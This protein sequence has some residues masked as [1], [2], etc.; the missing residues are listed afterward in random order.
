M[1]AICDVRH[2]GRYYVISSPVTL[3]QID[4]AKGAYAKKWGSDL[5]AESWPL[6]CILDV[7]GS[8]LAVKSTGEFL[9]QG[10]VDDLLLIDF[11]KKYALKTPDVK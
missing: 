10:K 9:K 11:L 4:A 7:D 6:F 2:F 3:K 8:T 1:I 5:F